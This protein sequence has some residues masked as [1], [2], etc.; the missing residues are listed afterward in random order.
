MSSLNQITL[1]GNV[2]GDPEQRTVGD[3]AVTAFSLAT[4][5]QWK[6]KDG[7]KQEKTEWHRCQAWNMGT[8]KL[9]DIAAQYVR[10]GDKVLVVG[11]LEYRE[12]EKDGVKR[13]SAEIR[14]SDIRLLGGKA[15]GAAPAARSVEQVLTP[16]EDDLPF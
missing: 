5:R 7:S 6:G 12:W 8:N 1:L 2:G 3:S 13:T 16:D 14:V 11:S 9:A 4:S 10:K 15:G